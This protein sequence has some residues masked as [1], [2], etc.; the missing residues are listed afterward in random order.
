MFIKSVRATRSRTFGTTKPAFS[1]K[2]SIVSSAICPN[3]LRSL[4]VG[5]LEN[6]FCTPSIIPIAFLTYVWVLCI[7]STFASRNSGAGAMISSIRMSAF[8]CADSMPLGFIPA[9]R[10]KKLPT[11]LTKRCNALMFE[12]SGLMLASS[13]W[14]AGF[15]IASETNSSRFLVP[16]AVPRL[17]LTSSNNLVSCLVVG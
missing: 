6:F 17:S 8:V 11:L 14:N 10:R 2:L 7:A 15:D 16:Y 13:A 1:P 4:F 5:G 12:P 3:F 9:R